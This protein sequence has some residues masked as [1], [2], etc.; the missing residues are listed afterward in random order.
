MKSV[1]VIDKAFTM[2]EPSKIINELTNT[3]NSEKLEEFK[4]E[5]IMPYLKERNIE[6]PDSKTLIDS[7]KTINDYTM[8]FIKR[9]RDG[10]IRKYLEKKFN[11]LNHQKIMPNMTK[12]GSKI[13]DIED[14]EKE[15]LGITFAELIYK[16]STFETKSNEY[17]KE[18]IIPILEKENKIVFDLS[19]NDENTKLITQRTLEL[20]L[21]YIHEQGSMTFHNSIFDGNDFEDIER[22]YN[23]YNFLYIDDK[24]VKEVIAN[25]LCK[26]FIENY[27]NIDLT[28]KT[29]SNIKYLYMAIPKDYLED[30]I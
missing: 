11:F 19:S 8:G 29:N 2:S 6:M 5:Y 1:S 15:L 27:N 20:F 30:Y 23:Y 9:W 21:K 28:Q 4:K 16:V 22:M 10:H 24:E 14:K 25:I 26:T 3:N 7:F 17:L 18:Y 13:F 12:Y